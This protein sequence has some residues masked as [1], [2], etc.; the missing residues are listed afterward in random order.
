[1][2]NSFRFTKCARVPG[3]AFVVLALSM[4]KPNA[5]HAEQA[6]SPNESAAAAALDCFEAWLDRPADFIAAV[7]C[8]YRAWQIAAFRDDALRDRSN[9]SR[10]PAT[11]DWLK[12]RL[13]RTR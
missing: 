12:A 9:Q 13:P 5:A 10:D 11:R 2:N 4:G 3:I 7:E 1:M 6:V 8:M